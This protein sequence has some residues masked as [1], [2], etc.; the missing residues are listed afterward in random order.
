MGGPLPD[1]L[2]AVA[3]PVSNLLFVGLVAGLVVT[4]SHLLVQ[5]GGSG[6]LAITVVVALSLSLPSLVRGPTP[7]RAAL[8]LTTGVRNLSLALLLS[9]TYFDALTTIT[10]LAYGLVMYLLS[11]PLA[12]YYRRSISRTP[13]V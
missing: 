5:V 11:V 9:T 12:L 13:E 2:N 3:R 7:D 8:A 4:K 10:V 6:M 1:R